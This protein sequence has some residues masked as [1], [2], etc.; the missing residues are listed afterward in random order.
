MPSA[1]RAVWGDLAATAFVEANVLFHALAPEARQDLLRLAQVE[2]FGAGELIASDGAD[3]RL[4]LL[5]E[6]TA[7]ARLSREGQQVEVGTLERNA[8]YGE[9]RV[10]GEPRAG[11]LVALTDVSVVTFP[12]PVMAA[13][14]SRFPKVQ[15]LLEAVRIARERDAA[16]K[17][18]A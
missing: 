18:G 7:T 2:D 5:R 4:Y 16:G 11:T 3:E 14:A 17:L 6:G 12:A 13:M 15:R 8:I 1:P 9:G 10:L